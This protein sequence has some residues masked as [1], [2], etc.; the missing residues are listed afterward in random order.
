[1]IVSD[2]GMGLQE[3]PGGW[4]QVRT[5]LNVPTSLEPAEIWLFLCTETADSH[6]RHFPQRRQECH[7]WCKGSGMLTMIRKGESMGRSL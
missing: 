6:F 5:G 3:K 4:A 2:I 7:V 1:M